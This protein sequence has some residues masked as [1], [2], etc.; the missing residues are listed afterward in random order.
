VPNF[1]Q[2]SDIKDTFSN[3]AGAETAVNHV[4]NVDALQIDSTLDRPHNRRD[5][6]N[7]MMM[8]DPITD[9][10]GEVTQ[11]THPAGPKAHKIN[12]F[13]PNFGADQEME[14]DKANIA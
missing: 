2:D 10:T 8:S 6:A 9:S 7:I 1:G 13:V 11:Y 14:S 4:W 5:R 12:Y 3:L